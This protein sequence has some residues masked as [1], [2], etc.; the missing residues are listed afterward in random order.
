VNVDRET[1]Y[2]VGGVLAVLVVA[3]V[4]GQILRQRVRSDAGRATVT[5]INQRIVAWWIMIG[6]FA[7]ALAIGDIASVILF[8]LISFLALRE[9]ITLTSPARGDHRALFWTFFIITPV[10]YY[11]VGIEWY[12]LFSIFIPVYAFLFLPVSNVFSGQTE[13]F[14]ERTAVIQWGLM[15]CVYLVSHAPAILIMLNIPGYEN[16]SGKLLMYFAIITQM[17]DVLQYVWGKLF[18]RHPIAPNVSPNK[19][20]EG[21]VG[22]VG[23][24]VIAGTLLWWATPFEP[25]QSALMA[26]LITVMGFLGGLTMSAIKRD[27]GV[28]DYGTLIPGHGG[29]LD[30]IDSLCFAAPIFFHVTRYYFG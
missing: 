26:L 29:I 20:W 15:V 4:L 8:G 13:R 1:V 17:S 6:V 12:G 11:L 3:T 10:Q 21:F 24:T 16:E 30:R 7:F 23:T 18:G 19:T 25:W 5:N 27:R 9:F 14:L 22:G 2:L 28:K